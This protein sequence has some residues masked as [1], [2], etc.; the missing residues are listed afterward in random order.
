MLSGEREKK[1]RER[2]P[3]L[4]ADGGGPQMPRKEKQNQKKKE[5]RKGKRKKSPG[6]EPVLGAGCGGPYNDKKTKKITRARASPWGRLWMAIEAVKNSKKVSALGISACIRR[7]VRF[8]KI[9]CV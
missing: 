9:H 3:V 5:K 1:L 4:V 7:R 8:E 6:R 2:E